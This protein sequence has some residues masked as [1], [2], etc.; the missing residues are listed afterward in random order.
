MDKSVPFPQADDFDKIIEILQFHNEED[1]NDVMKISSRLGDISD[2]QVSYY[3]SAA[4]FL[5]FVEK[6]NGKRVFS[7]HALEIKK[8]NTYMRNAEIISIILLNPVFNKIYVNSVLL[9]QQEQEAVVDILKQYYPEYSD[10]ILKR[11]SQTI[12]SWINWVLGHLS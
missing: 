4:M 11:R 10:A 12:I 3:I 7:K 6:K 2:R 8:M 1:L 9:G 5:G